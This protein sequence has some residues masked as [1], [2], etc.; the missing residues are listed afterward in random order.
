M[1]HLGVASTVHLSYLDEQLRQLLPEDL[2]HLVGNRAEPSYP[3]L[4]VQYPMGA[5]VRTRHLHL[6]A[7]AANRIIFVNDPANERLILSPLLKRA[8]AESQVF[9]ISGMN[10]MRDPRQVCARLRYVEECVEPAPRP[11]LVVYEDAGF[12][13]P[14]V[15]NLVRTH[16]AKLVDVYSLSDEE[17]SQAIDG[18]VDL[19]VPD[20]VHQ[21]VAELARRL[22]VPTLVVHTRR[23]ALAYGPDV[24][25]WERALTT[26]VALA[27]ARF[28]HG[29]QVTEE[30]VRDVAAMAPGRATA[31]FVAGLTALAGDRAV[32]VPVPTLG[33]TNPTTVGLGD[34]FIG[35]FLA[36]CSDPSAAIAPRREPRRPRDTHLAGP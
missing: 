18:R 19:L 29:D 7:P 4:I 16:M 22:N 24:S 21:A 12:H 27:G 2:G 31:D 11:R 10:A 32:V 9:L 36:A 26:G 5:T 28:L 13:E 25:R 20:S 8:V 1:Q 17:L 3:H 30:T 33:V 14:E 35:G 6:E 34:T 23:W 15:A